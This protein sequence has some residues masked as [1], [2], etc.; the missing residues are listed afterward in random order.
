MYNN[1]L[2]MTT[3]YEQKGNERAPA[4]GQASVAYEPQQLAT[5]LLPLASEPQ[6]PIVQPNK[7]NCAADAPCKQPGGQ[8]KCLSKLLNGSKLG[9]NLNGD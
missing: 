9:E 4:N 1:H 7:C 8:C 5:A 2:K 6:Q 3:Q